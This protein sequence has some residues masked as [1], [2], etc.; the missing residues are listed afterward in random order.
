MLRK[1]QNV[2]FWENKLNAHESNLVYFLFKSN[3]QNGE[4]KNQDNV[5]LNMTC[6]VTSRGITFWNVKMPITNIAQRASMDKYFRMIF[7]R[8]ICLIN[9]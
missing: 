4:I 9:G 7:I 5:K 2:L 8:W 3:I 6:L 1:F